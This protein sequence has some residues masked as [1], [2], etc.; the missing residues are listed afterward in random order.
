MLVLKDI[1]KRGFYPL[2]GAFRYVSVFLTILMYVVR[3]VIEQYDYAMMLLLVLSIA[4][5]VLLLNYLYRKS[6]DNIHRVLVLLVIEISALSFLTYIT[7]GLSSPFIWCFL[8]PLLIISSFSL[9]ARKI[10][11]LVANFILL[12]VI[13]YASERE[14]AVSEFFIARSNI[15]L[16]YLLILILVN[17]L[18]RYNRKILEKHQELRETKEQL[19]E[20]NRKIKGIIRD[21]LGMYETVHAFPGQESR[22]KI[23]DIILDFAERVSPEAQAFFMQNG[24][25]IDENPIITKIEDPL[26][27]EELYNLNI[28]KIPWKDIWT[29]RL[30]HGMM[31]AMIRVFNFRD[32]GVIGLVLPASEYNKAREEYDSN[33]LL[34]SRLGAT[35]FD[36]IETDEINYELAVA[37]EQKRIAEDIHDSV[38]QRLFAVSCFTYD[39]IKNWEQIPDA[40]K[41]EQFTTV[42]E[43]VQSSLRDLRS[44]IYNL[45]DRMNHTDQFR[46]SIE[47]YLESMGKLSGIDMHVDMKGNFNDLAVG[48]RKALYRIIAEGAGNAVKHASCSNIY[49]NLEV[50]EDKTVLTIKDD[51]IGFDVQKAEQEKRGLGLHNMKNLVRIFNGDISIISGEAEGTA[52]DIKFDSRD[53][54]KKAEY[55]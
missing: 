29:R 32:Y 41:K 5:S 10:F 38:V 3:G 44:T 35:F 19:E 12:C 48:A 46:G 9:S 22:R 14:T 18:L 50:N 17:I 25:Y 23:V 6:L 30:K 55:V 21:I 2:I 40:E 24:G 27:R 52:I 47:A 34:F 37:D 16:S 53:V 26:V 54:L 13:G 33:L 20:S 51:G 49:V 4:F 7:G 11:F 8:N 31:A 36:R 45:S 43:T 15:I 39:I 28:S 1:G 42:M